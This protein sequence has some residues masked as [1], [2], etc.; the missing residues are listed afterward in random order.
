MPSAAT[1]PGKMLMEQFMEP[2]GLSVGELADAL[3]VSD[4]QIDGI[5]TNR[6][7]IS[8]VMAARLASY[9]NTSQLY[10]LGAQEADDVA[11]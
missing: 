10:W 7:Q 4:K 1:C 6:C 9:F 11:A 2:A 3:G 8:E 5:I